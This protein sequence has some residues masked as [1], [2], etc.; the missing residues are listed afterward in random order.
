[1]PWSVAT[2]MSQRLDFV[3]D[4]QRGLYSMTE[5]CARSAISRKTGYKWLARYEAGGRPALRE[6][7]HA[8]R[9]WRPRPT[10]WRRSSSSG[11]ATRP[12]ARRSSSPRSPAGSRGSRC[13]RAAPPP[14]PP[15]QLQR[16]VS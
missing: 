16:H 14:Q 3:E 11:S 6:R 15:R 4:A 7:S 9:R 5:L 10:R 2:P 13:R 8:P 12:G 1:M